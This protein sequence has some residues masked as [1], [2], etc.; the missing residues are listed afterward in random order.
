MS[1]RTDAQ[2]KALRSATREKIL[3]AALS[4]F[5]RQG[6]DGASIR[7]IARAAG[8]APGLLYRHFRS[9]QDLLRSL[10][11][12]NMEDVRASFAAAGARPADALEALT[13]SACALLRRNLDFWRLSYG[14]RMQEGALRALGPDLQAWRREILAFL[15]AHFRSVRSAQ[16]AL[17]AALFFAALDGLCQ[18]FTLDPEH[19]PLEAVARS[20]AVRFKAPKRAVSRKK[21]D[22][23][24]QRSRRPRG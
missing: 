22:S 10:F 6:Y 14:V 24:A 16:P 5:A 11:K 20:L 1:P 18:H 23:H 19:Y 4:R 15:Q 3:S 12:R 8:M 13:R 9:K 7:E 17:D 2:N 21:G